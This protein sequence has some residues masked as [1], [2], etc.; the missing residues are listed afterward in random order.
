[1]NT[2]NVSFIEN[3]KIRRMRRRNASLRMNARRNDLNALQRHTRR[4]YDAKTR[5][6]RNDAI[7]EIEFALSHVLRDVLN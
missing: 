4:A 7:R 5:V 2:Q 1:M 3:A 6:E